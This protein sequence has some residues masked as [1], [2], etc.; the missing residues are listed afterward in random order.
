[1]SLGT[2]VKI[3][4]GLLVLAVVTFTLLLLRHVRVEPMGG[5]FARLVPVAVTAGP[6]V[7]L[8]EPNANLP[9]F[10]PGQKVFE[11]ARELIAVGDLG[12]ARDKLRMVVT[13][14]PRS[15]SAREARRILGEMNLDELFSAGHMSGKEIHVVE[16]GDSYLAIAA[17]HDTS[18][19][20][21]MHLNGLMDLSTLHP[22]D[23]LVV[24]PLDF[25]VL[26]EPRRG[27]L[28]L[29]DGAKFV[30][31]YHFEKVISPPSGDQKTKVDSRVGT[32]DGRRVLPGQAAYRGAS[33]VIGL[34]RLP[35]QIAVWT[36]GGDADAG[37][38]GDGANGGDEGFPRGFYLSRADIEELAI[39]LRPGNEV[40]IRSSSR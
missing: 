40:E 1:M 12:G 20:M 38:G 19:D 29:L 9:A 39:L 30:K 6:V 13:I 36:G 33:K 17:K 28:T 4:A 34:E 37:D 32:V 14:Y 8:P 11:R 35:H 18:L 22:G 26:I 10:D 25:K 21:L 3:V 7:E 24:M 2:L 15:A 27:T 31:E 23:E 16:R 5:I